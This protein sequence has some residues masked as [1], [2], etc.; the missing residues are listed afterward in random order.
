VP[1]ALRYMSTVALYSDNNNKNANKALIEHYKL[2]RE[3][4]DF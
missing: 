3:N 2:Q 4:V 1:F